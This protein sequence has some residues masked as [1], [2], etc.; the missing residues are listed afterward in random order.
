M[1]MPI[2]PRKAS[3]K[4]RSCR[5]P[6]AMSTR[7]CSAPAEGDSGG[8]GTHTQESAAGSAQRTGTRAAPRATFKAAQKAPPGG[9]APARRGTP[10][11]PPHHHPGVRWLCSWVSPSLTAGG[12]R[13]V[14][15]PPVPST[16]G[17]FWWRMGQGEVGCAAHP[18]RV[19]SPR[20]P[21][22][23]SVM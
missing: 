13:G 8:G 1:M 9:P 15:P 18:T 10:R 19:P 7:G 2:Q 22:A 12:P 20:H 5:P 17:W 6:L 4:P 21:S 11:P 14:K 23:A 3:T 16:V